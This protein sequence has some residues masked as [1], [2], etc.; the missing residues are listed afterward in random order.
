MMYRYQHTQHK[1]KQKKNSEQQKYI[2]KTSRETKAWEHY[3]YNMENEGANEGK[4]I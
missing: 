2:T 4:F 3:R 1:Q